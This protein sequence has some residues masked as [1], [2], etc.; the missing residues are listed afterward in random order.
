[1]GRTCEIC[2]ASEPGGLTKTAVAAKFTIKFKECSKCGLVFCSECGV[3]SGVAGA[4]GALMRGPFMASG[5]IC[6]RCNPNGLRGDGR[7]PIF[8]PDG[9][10]QGWGAK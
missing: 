7:R 5:V 4:L 9:T 3:F 10:F 8:G 1:M 2:G 6:P